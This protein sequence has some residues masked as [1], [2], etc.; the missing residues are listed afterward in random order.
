MSLVR[1][2]LR[3]PYTVFVL[4]VGAIAGALLA[5]SKMPAD[6]FPPL[7]VPT[8]CSPIRPCCVGR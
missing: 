7:G 5:I 2:A 8:I 3:R 4:V 1:L 6:V